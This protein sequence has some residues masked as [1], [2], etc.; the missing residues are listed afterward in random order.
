[1]SLRFRI[2]LL[3][4]MSLALF[5]G[6]LNLF[7]P[8]TIPYNFDRL[9]IFLF[10]LCSGG[11]IILYFTEGRQKVSPKIIVFLVMAIIYA[12]FAF[13]QIYI[14]VLIIT[15]VLVAIV[16]SSRIKKFSFF[17]FDFFKS[18]VP[19][20]AKFHQASLLC[21]SMGLVISGL[22]ILNNEYFFILVSFPK[23]QLDTFFLGFSFPLSLITMSLL[24][25]LMKDNGRPIRWMKNIGFWFVNLGV[26]IF[27]M[28]IIFEKLMPQVFVTSI[29][30]GAV[31]MILYLLVR[32]G[33]D[34]QQKA[35]LISGMGFLLYTALTGILYIVYE[36]S[37]DYASENYKWLMRMHSFASLYG[38][39]LCGL[40]IIC[41]FD[42]FPLKLH[43][44]TLIAFHWITVIFLAPMGMYY[45]FFACSATVCFVVILY[46]VMFT[47]GTTDSIVSVSK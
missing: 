28:F 47:K 18:K 4:L 9:H 41:R 26:I 21:L 7:I 24:F 43:S 5:F 27:F 11:S 38:W 16:E 30:F 33:D 36:M 44:Y 3:M 10:N 45:K 39:N 6:Y 14:P 34:L 42:D 31:I 23:L 13:F 40:A 22:V 20:S 35:F 29:L 37:P 1:M 32:L 17:P 19:V 8:E 15:L 2:F 25:S 46:T 12:I